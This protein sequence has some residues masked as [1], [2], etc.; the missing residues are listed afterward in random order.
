M[1]VDIQRLV[2]RY[3]QTNISCHWGVSP[4]NKVVTWYRDTA[5]EGVQFLYMVTYT[6]S[7]V[8]DSYASTAFK[9]RIFGND[10]HLIN[11]H[12]IRIDNVTEQDNGHYWCEMSVTGYDFTAPAKSMEVIG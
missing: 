4:D 3:T 7:K 9:E 8:K 12:N 10:D 6:N 11:Y 2:L 5:T 1:Y